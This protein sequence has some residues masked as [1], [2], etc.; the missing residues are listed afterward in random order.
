M[1]VAALGDHVSLTI[2]RQF[3]IKG[4]KGKKAAKSLTLSSREARRN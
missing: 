1:F 3:D 4:E 2:T